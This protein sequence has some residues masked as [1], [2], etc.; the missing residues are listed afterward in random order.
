MDTVGTVD[1][2]T[3]DEQ[4]IQINKRI[5]MDAGTGLPRIDHNIDPNLSPG[6]TNNS[7]IGME[8]TNTLRQT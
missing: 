4:F 6:N 2:H 5:P 3:S 1:D 7:P 8:K